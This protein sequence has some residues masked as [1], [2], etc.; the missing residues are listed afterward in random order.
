[1]AG[2]SIQQG[3]R[4]QQNDDVQAKI[5]KPFTRPNREFRMGDKDPK[6]EDDLL[7]TFCHGIALSLGNSERF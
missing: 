4:R 2:R 1:M 3:Q 7:D 6:R 5:K